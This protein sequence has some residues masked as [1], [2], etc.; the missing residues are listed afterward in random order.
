MT[1]EIS[2][3]PIIGSNEYSMYCED[4]CYL[5]TLDESLELLENMQKLLED[6]ESLF[7]DLFSG[8]PVSIV[9]DKHGA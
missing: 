5:E 9:K 1:C 7:G 6:P 3:K 2:G 8:I 4:K